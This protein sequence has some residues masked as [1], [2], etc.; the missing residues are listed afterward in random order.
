MAAE[1]SRKNLACKP[2]VHPTW[3]YR[4]PWEVPCP[5]SAAGEGEAE[6]A[7]GG[8]AP[9]R[10]LDGVP[11][12]PGPPQLGGLRHRRT[13]PPGMEPERCFGGGTYLIHMNRHLS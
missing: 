12:A 10:G 3:G 5:R 9:G 7:G 4:L 2:N 1:L 13:H 6:V 8:G 11:A